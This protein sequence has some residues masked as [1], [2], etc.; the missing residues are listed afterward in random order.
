MIIQ[1]NDN[2]DFIIQRDGIIDVIMN[3]LSIQMKNPRQMIIQNFQGDIIIQP[4]D[5]IKHS[6]FSS[7]PMITSMLP[8]TQAKVSTKRS[9]QCYHPA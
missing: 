7:T 6:E 3:L 2:I 9:G 4:A 1:Q 5:N 8:S